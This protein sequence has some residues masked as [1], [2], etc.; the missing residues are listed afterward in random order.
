[1]GRRIG[2]A[3][4]TRRDGRARGGRACERLGFDAAIGMRQEKA[5]RHG[6]L[7]VGFGGNNLDRSKFQ[8]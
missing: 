6:I 4:E 7:P 1:M 8:G 5:D 2:D 3:A